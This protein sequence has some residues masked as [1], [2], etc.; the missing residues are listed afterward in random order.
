MHIIVYEKN[1]ETEEKFYNIYILM[2]PQRGE[3]LKKIIVG[4]LISL[5]VCMEKKREKKKQTK[6]KNK[7]K[8]ET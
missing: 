4:R 5:C 2:M 7:N 8:P 3:S 6:N 1:F